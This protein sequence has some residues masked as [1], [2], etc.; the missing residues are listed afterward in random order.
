MGS[1]NVA[2]ETRTISESGLFGGFHK[3]HALL[4]L[5]ISR[6]QSQQMHPD[7]GLHRILTHTPEVGYQSNSYPYPK[8]ATVTFRSQ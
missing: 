2:N 4:S 6:H 8:S 7:L 1:A 5:V 3:H